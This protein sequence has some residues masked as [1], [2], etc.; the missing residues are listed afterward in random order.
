MAAEARNQPAWNVSKHTC[1]LE[2]LR[3]IHLNPGGTKLL[4]GRHKT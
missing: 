2:L 3:W 4:P 1:L